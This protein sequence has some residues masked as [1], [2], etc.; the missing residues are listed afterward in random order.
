MPDLTH[1]AEPLRPLAVPVDTLVLDPANV[2]RHGP[3]NLDTIKASLQRF[4]FRQPIV[5][6]R[7]GMVVRSG[8]ARVTVALGLGWTHVPAVIVDEQ[9]VEATAYA[10]ADNRTAE[11]AEWDD[12]GLAALLQSL[13][14][15]AQLAA[16]WDDG[17]LEALLRDTKPSDP[18]PIDH[19]SPIKIVWALVGVPV[20]QWG[21]INHVIEGLAEVEGAIVKTSVQ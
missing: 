21:Q 13:P 8:N 11:L 16:G 5:V 1:I 7:Q 15:D 3:R 12:A 14:T 18:I 6:Q 17:E 2:R 10:I 20:N 4:G 19:Q 9:D